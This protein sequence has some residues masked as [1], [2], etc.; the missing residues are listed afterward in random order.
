VSGDRRNVRHD[1]VSSL[2]QPSASLDDGDLAEKVRLEQDRVLL[3]LELR[4]QIRLRQF[5][6][7]DPPA[8][9][10]AGALA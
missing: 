7:A 3:A 5:D 10:V 6:K 1:P 2:R 4:E 8:H 9:H